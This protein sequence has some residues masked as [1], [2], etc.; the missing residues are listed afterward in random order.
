MEII[1]SKTGN[2]C[3]GDYLLALTWQFLDGRTDLI[4]AQIVLGES[5]LIPLNT[6]F[7]G[8]CGLLID[9]VFRGGGGIESHI[10]TILIVMSSDYRF[11]SVHFLIVVY[12]PKFAT[13]SSEPDVTSR[14][15]A[16]HIGLGLHCY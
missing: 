16:F 2:A 4:R 14:Y 9:T 5:T 12:Y 11:L 7:A 15:V 6:M 1:L 13:N 10:I 3:F 8:I